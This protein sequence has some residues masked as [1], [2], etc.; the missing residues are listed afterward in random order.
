MIIWNLPSTDLF[1]FT[2]SNFGSAIIRSHY[3]FSYRGSVC[4]FR[5]TL[6]RETLTP[7]H[8]RESGEKCNTHRTI[9]IFNCLFYSYFKKNFLQKNCLWI[10]CLWKSTVKSVNIL[11]E[12]APAF[13]VSYMF[14]LKVT[15]IRPVFSWK[16]T[17]LFLCGRSDKTASK[18][19]R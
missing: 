17:A 6:L 5:G 7:T 11:V 12:Q 4:W 19:V 14:S 15:F 10:K 3:R 16:V 8:A 2:F 1:S 13:K 18:Y 9:L